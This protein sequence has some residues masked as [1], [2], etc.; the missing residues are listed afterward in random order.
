M[1][2]AMVVVMALLEEA[3]V[4]V[5]QELTE[6][7]LKAVMEVLEHNGLIV[8]IMLVAVAVAVKELHKVAVK[9]VPEAAATARMPEA[10]VQMAVQVL[11]QIPE[12]EAVVL[13]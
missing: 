2:A 6:L 8:L 9:A 5:V 13:V 12:V 11:Q 3:A 7:E 4:K 10:A 1:M